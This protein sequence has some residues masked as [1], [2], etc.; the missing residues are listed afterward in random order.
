M[1]FG[2]SQCGQELTT[3]SLAKPHLL[4]LAHV[5]AVRLGKLGF[6]FDPLQK[7]DRVNRDHFSHLLDIHGHVIGAALVS[8]RRLLAALL[9]SLNPE[10]VDYRPPTFGAM[11]FDDYVGVN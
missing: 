11:C 8:S 4:L 10:E 1:G 3:S 7:T 2:S 6:E 9:D 5:N